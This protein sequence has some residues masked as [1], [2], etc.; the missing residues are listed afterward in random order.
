MLR[1]GRLYSEQQHKTARPCRRAAPRCHPQ[2]G[3]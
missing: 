2:D 3:L 1:T